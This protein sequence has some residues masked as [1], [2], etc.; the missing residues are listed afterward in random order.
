MALYKKAEFAQ[1]CGISQAYLTMY[2]K[3]GKVFIQDDGMIDGN[4]DHNAAF[5]QRCLSKKPTQA[6]DATSP[7]IETSQNADTVVKS[8]KKTRMETDNTPKPTE[9]ET[10]AKQTK[11]DEKF[12][13]DLAK[14]K[15]SIEKLQR[16]ARLAELQHQRQI[17]KLMPKDAVKTIFIQTIKGYTTAFKQAADK[18]AVD[19]GAKN[20]LSRNDMAE[21]RSTIIS[22]INS[23]GN[24][25]TEEGIRAVDNVV[26][27]YMQLKVEE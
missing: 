15:I 12:D 5:Y 2:I 25:A 19:F 7:I 24:S 21:L 16:E 3:R 14:Q 23:A 4:I 26:Q 17:G 13:L 11:Y 10:P 27:E 1:I 20:K 22:A 6:D 18:I 9:D 8:H